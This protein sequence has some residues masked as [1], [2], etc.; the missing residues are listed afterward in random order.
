MHQFMSRRLDLVALA[1]QSQ[2]SN[3]L[4]NIYRGF[5][6]FC[7][8]HVFCQTIAH[9]FLLLPHSTCGQSAEWVL[10]I[11]KTSQ[12]DATTI[13]YPI[14]R[15]STLYSS[16]LHWVLTDLRML[17]N[18]CFHKIFFHWPTRIPT[19][20]SFIQSGPRNCC[21]LKCE[22]CRVLGH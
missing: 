14:K 18:C 5:H 12:Q 20:S 3:K 17:N 13:K 22:D 6:E 11:Q 4:L 7:G 15:L 10:L 21:I 16:L 8:G 19:W 9:H 2:H 1:N